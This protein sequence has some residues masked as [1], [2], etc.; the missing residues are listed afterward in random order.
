MS[1]TIIKAGILDTI[2]DTGRYGYQSLGINPGGSMDR[3][4]AQLSNGLLGK[5]MSAPVIEMHFPASTIQFNEAT[6]ICIAGADFSPVIDKK[7]IPLHQPVVINKDTILEF[8]KVKN[9]S[10]CYLSILQNFHLSIW[11]NS[12]STNLKAQAGGFEGRALK[13]GDVIGF[14]KNNAFISYLAGRNV[15]VLPWKAQPSE[16]TA[17][18]KI[19]VIEGKEWSWLTEESQ[20]W[21]KNNSFTISNVADR[22]G[23]R[24]KGSELTLKEQ[25]QLISSGV[26]FGTIQLLPNGQLIVLMADNQTTGGYPRI[27][28]IISAHLPALAQ[29]KPND[30]FTFRMTDNSIAEKKVLQQH[31]YLLSVQH[32]SAFKIKNLF[33]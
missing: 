26:A 9:G 25:K 13:N 12:Y 14:E 33:A 6:I 11:L 10:R 22:M 29:M 23:Y 19:E 2:Q 21:F 28:N 17:T 20:Q 4:F 30:R 15:V 1:F 3:F 8:E 5:E 24:L 7:P 27:A 16:E 18:D 32:A 31:N